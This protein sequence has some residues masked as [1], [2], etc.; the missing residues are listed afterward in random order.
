MI[1]FQA[2]NLAM[3]WFFYHPPSW[4]EKRA[5]HGKPAMQLVREF[6]WLGLFLFLAG[7]TLFIVVSTSKHPQRNAEQPLTSHRA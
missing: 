2:I 6:D 4:K 7:C 5:Q 1:A 3:L